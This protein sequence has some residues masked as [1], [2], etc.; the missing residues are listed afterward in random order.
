[1]FGLSKIFSFLGSSTLAVFD[2]ATGEFN[3][4]DIEVAKRNLKLAKRATQN[5]RKGI[6]GLT[7]SGKDAMAVEIDTY[8]NDLVF[9]ARNKFVDRLRAIDDLNEAQSQG[10]IQTITEIYEKSKSELETKALYHQNALF[11]ARKNWI[12]GYNQLETFREE[13]KLK[14]PAVYPD[15]MV[16]T[17]VWMA[18]IVVAE[19]MVNAWVLGEAHPRGYGS[20]VTEIFMFGVANVLAAFL[21]GQG[22]RYF[23]H[24]S[25]VKKTV[26][27]I[28]VVAMA[29]LICFLNLLLAHYRDAIS[30]LTYEDLA[31]SQTIN[32]LGRETMDA[33]FTNPFVMNDIKSYLILIVGLMASSVAAWKSF[34]LFDSYPGYEKISKEHEE[35]TEDFNDKQTSAFRE[36]NHLVDNCSR[37][38]NSQLSLMKSNESAL[39][40][41]ERDRNQLFEKYNNWLMAT[42]SVG[43][44]LYAFYRQENMKARK[45]NEE[46]ECFSLTGFALPNGVKIKSELQKHTTFNYET[47]EK[48][49]KKYLDEMNKWSY[50]FQGK[51]KDIE[52]MPPDK[53]LNDKFK[54]SVV[55]EE[56]NA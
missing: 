6:P 5:G 24:V 27:T 33:L 11:T 39:L 8:I 1:M 37:Q 4:I 7:E 28:F 25:K 52:N 21:L 15:N 34:G 14:R 36:M 26:S 13:N 55:Y 42:Q 16:E 29:T 22:W 31:A 47:T 54:E 40:N 53:I 44:A 35:R 48:T 23:S 2:V 38:I 17:S 56:R 49:C 20:V 9:L 10:S 12:L 51:F 46:P 45:S 50:E 19:M 3:P 32:L 30:N 18:F 41:R 43:E